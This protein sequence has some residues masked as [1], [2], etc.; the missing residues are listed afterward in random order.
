[1]VCSVPVWTVCLCV[2]RYKKLVS[3]AL[4]DPI[5]AIAC[6]PSLF[7]RDEIFDFVQGQVNVMLELRLAFLQL[8]TFADIKQ[9]WRCDAGPS[10]F[11]LPLPPLRTCP[12]EATERASQLRP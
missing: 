4:V 5:N 6:I 12:E 10:L 8:H 11:P 3:S 7:V 1:M 2:V 9:Q